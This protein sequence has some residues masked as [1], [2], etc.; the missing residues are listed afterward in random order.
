MSETV[1]NARS[2]AEAHLYL[3][4]TACQ[5]CGQGPLYARDAV[6]TRTDGPLALVCIPTDCGSCGTAGQIEFQ[7][8]RDQLQIQ[9]GAEI[10]RDLGPSR[11][12]DVGQWITLFRVITEAAD[13][14][15]D[16]FQV[17]RF[18]IQASHC[19]DEALKFYLPDNDLPPPTAIF[20]A[21]SR[22]RFS[23]HP[24]QFSRRRI[25]EI[26]AKLPKISK[27]FEPG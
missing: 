8:P 13:R 2:L 12:L 25:L 24:E 6:S 4:V 3:M 18:G 20:C 5:K 14:S 26:R 15:E 27:F 21:A 1:L 11:I 19:L 9:P 7:V 23:D 10:S 16:K 17:R 22:R